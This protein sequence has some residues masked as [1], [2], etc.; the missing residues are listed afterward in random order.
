MKKK[1]L[2]KKNSINSN[3]GIISYGRIKS[4]KNPLQINAKGQKVKFI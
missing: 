4:K 1:V 2:P 3:K